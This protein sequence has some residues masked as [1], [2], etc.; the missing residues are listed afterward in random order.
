MQT[1]SQYPKPTFPAPPL[2]VP[3][4]GGGQWTLAERR[5]ARFTMIVFYRGLHCP[6]CRA[7][8]GELNGLLDDFAAR[9]VEV[10]AVS[11]DTEDRARQT[12]DHW[13]L[14]HLT[15]GYAQPVASMRAW[16]LFVSHGIKEPEPA[17]FAEPGLFL[18]RPDATVHY[19]AVNSLPFGRPPLREMLTALD[20]II[21]KDYPAR[22]EA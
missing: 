14:S 12:V 8:L 22:G 5:P 16:G 4:I 19:V 10:I 9:G 21:A 6:I 2:S 15:V 7:Y 13:K 18:I 17:L 1:P 11:G 3:I 20:F